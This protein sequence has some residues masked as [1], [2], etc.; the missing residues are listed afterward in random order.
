MLYP[1]RMATLHAIT[2]KS[3]KTLARELAKARAR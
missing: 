3:D 1:K 2:K